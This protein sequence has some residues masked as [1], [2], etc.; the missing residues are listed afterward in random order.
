[1]ATSEYLRGHAT[2]PKP[3]HP[4]EL[5]ANAE[6]EPLPGPARQA[7]PTFKRDLLYGAAS[8]RRV[9]GL[10]RMVAPVV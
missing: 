5:V 2:R 8:Q 9:P 4:A 10:I 7:G 1:M 3:C 6:Y